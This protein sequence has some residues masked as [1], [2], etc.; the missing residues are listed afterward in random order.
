MKFLLLLLLP[1]ALNAG[2]IPLYFGTYTNGPSR[3][4]YRGSLDLETG[5]LKNLGLAVEASNP[6]F[7]AVHPHKPWVFAVSEIGAGKVSAYT[8]QPDGSLILQNQRSTHGAAPCHI[9]LDRSGR[10]VLV[11]NYSSGNIASYTL[12]VDGFLSE[13]V[14]VIQHS[15]SSAH[16]RRQKSPHAHSI[17]VDTTNKRVFVADL[18]IDKL[19]IYDLNQTTGALSASTPAFMSLEA[20]SGPRHVAQHFSGSNVYVLNE[21]NRT[22]AAFAQDKKDGQLALIQRISTLPEGAKAEGSTAE[23]AIH[24]TGR[25]LYASNRGHDSIAAYAINVFTGRL[26]LI[27]HTPI[28]GQTPR[29]FAI[30]PDGRFLLAAGQKSCTVHSFHI[31]PASGALRPVFAGSI[32]VPHPVCIVF[33]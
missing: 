13:P 4:I 19:M 5:K 11:A 22:I 17:D 30:T 15:G 33:P 28:I 9:S 10:I 14:S 18:G 25:Y 26:T 12:D 6:S 23:I 29:H 16:P 20:Q 7:L 1:L 32:S 8:I 27:G 24:P 21:M 2:H 3:G 31:D